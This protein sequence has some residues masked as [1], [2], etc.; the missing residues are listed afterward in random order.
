[1]PY[2]DIKLNNILKYQRQKRQIIPSISRP[3]NGLNKGLSELYRLY[4]SNEYKKPI[5]KK[6]NIPYLPNIYKRNNI[7]GKVGNNNSYV[8]PNN[9]NSQKK[10]IS[11][12]IKI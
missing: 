2:S 9:L 5:G 4:V 12:N 10:L 7:N 8:Y 11:L 6:N 1:M 3:K